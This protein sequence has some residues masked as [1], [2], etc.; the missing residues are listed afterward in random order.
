LQPPATAP[1]SEQKPA[2]RARRIR[3]KARTLFRDA[4][5][6]LDPSIR[7]GKIDCIVMLLAESSEMLYSATNGQWARAIRG[8]PSPERPLPPGC[9]PRVLAGAPNLP[10]ASRCGSSRSL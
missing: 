6:A 2:R 8:R 4:R 5:Q 9:E 7:D 10:T 1:G 3:C